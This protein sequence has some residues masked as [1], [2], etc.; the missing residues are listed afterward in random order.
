MYAVCKKKAWSLLG[1]RR[2]N[3]SRLR[4]EKLGC[5]RG[6]SSQAAAVGVR[7]F[8]LSIIAWILNEQARVF[9]GCRPVPAYHR[10]T[11]VLLLLGSLQPTHYT[12]LRQPWQQPLQVFTLSQ[13]LFCLLLQ[14]ILT[15]NSTCSPLKS[16]IKRFGLVRGLCSQETLFLHR[17]LISLTTLYLTPSLSPLFWVVPGGGRGVCGGVRSAKSHAVKVV[18]LCKK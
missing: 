2:Q 16:S 8:Q 6:V 11:F 12:Y 7:S 5:V 17:N 4:V 15:Q 10:Y 1:A 18:R 9:L 3:L 14:P 13:S